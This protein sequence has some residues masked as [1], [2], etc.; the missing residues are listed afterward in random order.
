MKGAAPPPG[1]VPPPF[2]P[3]PCA[4]PR[5]AGM[6]ASN[7]DR[8]CSRHRRVWQLELFDRDCWRARAVASEV[9]P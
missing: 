3:D 1:H 5:C 6:T 8:F 2:T 4:E 9:R 7:Y